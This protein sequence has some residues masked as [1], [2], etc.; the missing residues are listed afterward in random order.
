MLEQLFLSD[1]PGEE[2][3]LLAVRELFRSR[4]LFVSYNGKTFDSHLLSA[5]FRMNRLAPMSLFLVPQDKPPPISDLSMR[6][7]ASIPFSIPPQ[8]RNTSPA[9]AVVGG[10]SPADEDFTVAL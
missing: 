8:S 6:H 9:Y 5:R 3:F 7:A 10:E 4:K 2:E 1:F